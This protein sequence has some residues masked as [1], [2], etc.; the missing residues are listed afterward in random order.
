LKG[1]CFPLF[2]REAGAFALPRIGPLAKNW[3]SYH[4]KRKPSGRLHA[5][6]CGPG[7]PSR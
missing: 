5:A 2:T 6:G 4:T 3:Q 1:P 7:S